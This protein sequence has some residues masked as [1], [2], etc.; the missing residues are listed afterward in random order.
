MNSQ[1]NSQTSIS[2]TDIGSC[3]NE[4]DTANERLDSI[5][6]NVVLRKYVAIQVPIIKQWRSLGVAN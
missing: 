1:Q 5:P 4:L 2:D 3:S 6:G